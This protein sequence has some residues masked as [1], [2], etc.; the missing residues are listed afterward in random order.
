VTC[1]DAIAVLA[2]YLDAMLGPAAAETL[3]AHLRGATPA[4]VAKASRVE[5]PPE[6]RRRLREFLLAKL[7]ES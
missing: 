1:R 3:E 4:L 6:M 2:D 7:G 5:M